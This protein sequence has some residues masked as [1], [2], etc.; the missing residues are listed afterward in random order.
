MRYFNKDAR[1]VFI[2]RI[3]SLLICFF[4]KWRLRK[5][6]GAITILFDFI[7]VE[8]LLVQRVA[9]QSRL[10]GTISVDDPRVST[11]TTLNFDLIS[12][13]ETVASNDYLEIVLPADLDSEFSTS[14]TPSCAVDNASISACLITDTKTARIEFASRMTTTAITGSVTPFVNPKSNRMQSNI[15][16]ALYN[17][18]GEQRFLTYIG[19]LSSFETASL[20]ASLS[21]SSNVV[22]DDQAI[23]QIDIEPETTMVASGQVVVRFPDYYENAGSDQMIAETDPSCS[24]DTLEITD[25]E[26]APASRQLSIYYETSDG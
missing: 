26:F 20:T 25:C 18:F 13:G 24:S 3:F 12:T 9:A 21:S 6:M 7:A 16:I 10:L 1:R 14:G 19:S 8:E 22:G 23:L 15:Q 5:N 4:G 17:T 11:V 2:S